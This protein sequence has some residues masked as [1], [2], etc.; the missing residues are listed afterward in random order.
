MLLHVREDH[1]E[2]K[3]L[4]DNAEEEEP[5]K[6]NKIVETRVEESKEEDVAEKMLGETEK[7]EEEK[8]EKDRLETTI[9]EDLGLEGG[10][11]KEIEE[12]ISR[13]GES[14][15]DTP[16][17]KGNSNKIQ[18]KYRQIFHFLFYG[19]NCSLSNRFLAGA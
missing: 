17:Y 12:N 10:C 4:E 11:I 5:N 13:E 6:M 14:P 9:H 2:E 3:T 16:V 1:H 15:E 7:V 19:P 18:K 8:A